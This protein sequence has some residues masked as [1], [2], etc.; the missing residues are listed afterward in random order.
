MILIPRQNHVILAR[1]EEEESKQ[2]SVLL[3]PKKDESN[4]QVCEIIYVAEI[5]NFFTDSAALKSG[6]LVLVSTDTLNQ[7]FAHNK[8][9]YFITHIDNILGKVEK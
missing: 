5:Q 8:E 4:V 6:D 1:V 3:I 7:Q 2:D 9:N